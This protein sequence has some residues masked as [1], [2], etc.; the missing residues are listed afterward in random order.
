MR[1]LGDRQDGRLYLDN[2][3]VER[4]VDE[5]IQIPGSKADKQLKSA[6]EGITRTY[7]MVTLLPIAGPFGTVPE[8]LFEK[9]QLIPKLQQL[10]TDNL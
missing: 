1:L 3:A 2:I 7:S 9:K 4:L 6:E 10:I 5:L 8:L